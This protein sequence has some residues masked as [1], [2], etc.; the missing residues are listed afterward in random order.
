ML[1]IS[2]VVSCKK[3]DGDK[4][5]T[6]NFSDAQGTV[7]EG[8]SINIPV[9][10]EMNKNEVVRVRYTV[11]S[12]GCKIDEDFEL[13]DFSELFFAE[14]GVQY[15]PIKSYS[16][17]DFDGERSIKIT[18]QY[19]AKDYKTDRAVY[20]L[21]ILDDENFVSLKQDNYEIKEGEEITIPVQLARAPSEDIKISLSHYWNKESGDDIY[22]SNPIVF[23]AGETE[24]NIRVVCNVLGGKS[25]KTLRIYISSTPDKCKKDNNTVKINMK[26]AAPI[27]DLNQLVGKYH[28]SVKAEGSSRATVVN[29]ST[30]GKGGVDI[31]GLY[32]FSGAQDNL[33]LNAK[34][35]LA[36]QSLIIKGGTLLTKGCSVN[37]EQR[38]CRLYTFG[39]STI[40]SKDIEATMTGDLRIRLKDVAFCYMKPGSDEVSEIL[41]FTEMILVKQK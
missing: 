33:P 15:I 29:I 31:Y 34:V 22:V 12:I 8:R 10:A 32:A 30:D 4:T 2:V 18:L 27:T 37:G 19:S 6:I 17:S 40:Y 35:D 24:K 41:K 11:E 9:I 39:G 21:T 23:K 3:D 28:L 36:S 7:K 16:N 5:G 26:K 25:D 13:G 38:D 20:T 1:L 14:T